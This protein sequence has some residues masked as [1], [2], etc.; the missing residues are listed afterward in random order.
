MRNRVGPHIRDQID[1]D[2]RKRVGLPQHRMDAVWNLVNEVADVAPRVWNLAAAV[3]DVKDGVLNL[4]DEVCN[5]GDAV[6]NL[7]DEVRDLIF[8]GDDR[9]IGTRYEKAARRR[10]FH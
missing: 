3:A 10:P 7:V 6:S 5:V 4:G 1:N 9:M 8:A 2:V